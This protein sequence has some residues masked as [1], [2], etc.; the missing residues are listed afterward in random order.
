MSNARTPAVS[1][2][3]RSD[4]LACEQNSDA[5]GPADGL[6]VPERVRIETDGFDL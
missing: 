2:R 6:P 4:R 3:G 1:I 5:A